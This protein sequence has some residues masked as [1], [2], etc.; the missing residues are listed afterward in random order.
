MRTDRRHRVPI[1]AVLAA[2]LAFPSAACSRPPKPLVAMDADIRS[3]LAAY[4]REAVGA[5]K[6]AVLEGRGG[7]VTVGAS[8]CDYAD[9]GEAL[10]K[11]PAG[12][13]V[14]YLMDPLYSG[15]SLRLRRDASLVGFGALDTVIEGAPDPMDA[16]GGVLSIAPGVHAYVSGVTVRGGKVTDV[17]RRGGGVSNSGDLV[18]EDCAVVDNLATYGVG[19]WTEGRAELRRCAIAGNRGLRRPP[20]DE[21]A[22]VDCGGKGA[23]LRVEKGGFALVE[24]SV[25]AFN[26]SVSSGGALHVS[27]EAGAR[28][29]DCVLFGNVAKDR[30]GA[31]DSAGGSIEMLRCTVAGNSAGAKGQAI[32]HRG[33][34][35]I[36]GCLLADNG[37][38]KAYYLATG[39]LGEY[40]AGVF[41]LNEGNFDA[42][43]S[44]PLAAT[45]DA[46]YIRANARAIR[47]SY[48]AKRVDGPPR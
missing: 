45:G 47:S 4:D 43:G 17:P 2:T 19:V 10:E 35:S 34:L 44:L 1:L 22:A 41:G 31:V 42:S 25:I 39:S 16:E 14:F 33:K 3:M 40:G 36:S 8:G 30:G 18:M 20:A 5:R 32:F 13:F 27:C 23:G 9:I 11:A 15:V 28:L 29:V 26:R 7:Y 6:A 48:G 12:V 46:G 24:D 37:A 21:Y 38:G